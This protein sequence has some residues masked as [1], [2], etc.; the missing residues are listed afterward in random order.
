M[1]ICSPVSRSATFQ[2]AVSWFDRFFGEAESFEPPS[3]SGR[4]PN[5]AIFTSSYDQST[6]G[7]PRHSVRRRLRRVRDAVAQRGI[8]PDTQETYRNGVRKATYRD[9]DG[10]KISVGGADVSEPPP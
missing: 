6:P 1:S 3:A 4:Y 2:R 5:T 10:N 8:M 9:P 7:T